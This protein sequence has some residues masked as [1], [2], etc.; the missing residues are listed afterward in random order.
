VLPYFRT[1]E[2]W[3]GEASELHGKGGFLTTSPM[4]E[5]GGVPGDH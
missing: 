1:A 4:S 3:Q 2:N 5:P